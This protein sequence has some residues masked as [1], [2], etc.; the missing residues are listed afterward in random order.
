MSAK[1]KPIVYVSKCLGFDRCR[2]NGL[3]ISSDFVRMLRGH[4]RTALICPEVEIGLGVPR[5][6]IRAVSR[7]GEVRLMQSETG[8]DVT[9]SINAYV[10]ELIAS[11]GV[12]DGFILKSR[13]PTC[14]NSGVKLYPKLGKVGAHGKTTGFV[15]GPI[16]EH[17]QHLPVEDEGRLNNYRI[18][19]HFLTRIFGSARLRAAR[20]AGG[21]RDLVDFHS[22]N[23]YML[24]AY[25][26]KELRDLGRVVANHERKPIAEVFAEYERGYHA[27]M[28]GPPRY[29]SQLNA[30]QHIAGHVS[31]HLGKEE[32]WFLHDAIEK[33]REERVPISVPLFVLRSL[34]IRFEDEY[35]R[36]QAF[37]EPYPEALVSIT[38]SGK[39][40]KLG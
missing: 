27:A 6:P 30:L 26:Q 12:V 23:K 20:E 22:R 39:G 36:N 17:F 13:S 31:K 5:Y 16:A 40:R 9:D 37:F 4:V 34:A 1:P 3:I 15:G 24:M 10:R 25:S 8:A 28:A 14:G 19:D 21:M 38:D 7:D 2:Y 35:I 18:R 33:F 32:R 29:T 11:I